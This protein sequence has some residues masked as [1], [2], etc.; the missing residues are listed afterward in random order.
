MTP[1]MYDGVKIRKRNLVA[2]LDIKMLRSNERK[3][4]ETKKSKMGKQKGR[5]KEASKETRVKTTLV[6]RT[7]RL[8]LG[9]QKK[10]DRKHVSRHADTKGSSPRKPIGSSRA[11]QIANSKRPPHASCKAVYMKE[12][13]LGIDVLFK[14]IFWA[15]V[16]QPCGENAEGLLLTVAQSTAGLGDVS[17]RKSFDT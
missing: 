13:P 16:S 17:V 3:S 9:R 14:P 10:A 11:N 7:K 5:G 15:K 8:L 4:T 1:S 12:Q 6:G 2:R